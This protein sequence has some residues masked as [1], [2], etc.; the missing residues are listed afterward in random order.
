MFRDDAAHHRV[1]DVTRGG[2]LRLDNLAVSTSMERS[3]APAKVFSP[4]RSEVRSTNHQDAR[5][6]TPSYGAIAMWI[7]HGTA[8]GVRPAH[9]SAQRNCDERISVSAEICLAR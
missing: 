2:R 6:R 1:R 3:K 8:G 9:R 4:D 5:S 7:S